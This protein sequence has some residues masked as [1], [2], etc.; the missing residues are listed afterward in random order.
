MMGRPSSLPL[1][2]AGLLGPAFY[3][4]T[5]CI[6]KWGLLLSRGH[7]ADLATTWPKR[8]EPKLVTGLTGR[9]LRVSKGQWPFAPQAPRLRVRLVAAAS[10]A[11]CNLGT[12]APGK[13]RAEPGRRAPGP[14]E[15][16]GSQL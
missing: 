14:F 13:P 2:R 11:P 16:N 15:V 6:A 9:A 1:L 8:H 4:A 5:G 7:G 12:R 3:Y 10:S